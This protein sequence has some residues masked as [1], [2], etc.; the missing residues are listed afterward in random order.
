LIDN[1]FFAVIKLNVRRLNFH[2][3]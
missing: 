3:F 1:P 2:H